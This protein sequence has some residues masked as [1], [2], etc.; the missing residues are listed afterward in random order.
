MRVITPGGVR[1]PNAPLQA[2]RTASGKT[3]YLTNVAAAKPG[4]G[5]AGQKIVVLTQ[6]HGALA[7]APHSTMPT[8]QTGQN[9]Q[10]INTAGTTYSAPVAM[11]TGI[12]ATP[13]LPQN[14]LDEGETATVSSQQ[15]QQISGDQQQ[16]SETPQEATEETPSEPKV[17]V[18]QQK[19]VDVEMEENNAEA[20]KLVAELKML[21]E[22]SEPDSFHQETSAVAPATEATPVTQ[23]QPVGNVDNSSHT[24]MTTTL[25][26]SNAPINPGRWTT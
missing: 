3:L 26:D 10:E 16:Q 8:D 19:V 4:E 11:K 2:I 14:I 17:E 15:S 7:S 20:D 22:Q 24:D 18:P 12:V 1:A 6:P 9:Q 23:Q 25:T 21:A 5:P 13:Q